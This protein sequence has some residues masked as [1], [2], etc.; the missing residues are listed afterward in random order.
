MN[1]HPFLQTNAVKPLNPAVED[2]GRHS[3]ATA[4]TLKQPKNRF[5]FAKI[6]L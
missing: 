4:G 5:F 2:G 6:P 3:G 1:V